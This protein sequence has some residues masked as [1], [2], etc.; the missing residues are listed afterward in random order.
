MRL[1]VLFGVARAHFCSQPCVQYAAV[2]TIMVSQSVVGKSVNYNCVRTYVC[3]YLCAGHHWAIEPW[4]PICTSIGGP[5][6]VCT[7]CV[8]VIANIAHLIRMHVW[9][10]ALLIVLSFVWNCLYVAWDFVW[11]CVC[12]APETWNTFE[13]LSIYSRFQLACF[14]AEKRKCEPTNQMQATYTDTSRVLQIWLVSFFVC[15]CDGTSNLKLTVCV[16]K[17]HTKEAE[18]ASFI[19]R[20]QQKMAYPLHIVRWSGGSTSGPRKWSTRPWHLLHSCAS[21]ISSRG[22]ALGPPPLP[23]Q[24][25]LHGSASISRVCI[26]QCLQYYQ[27]LLP[28]MGILIERLFRPG[29]MTGPGGFWEVTGHRIDKIQDD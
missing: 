24:P 8:L 28:P 9:K 3:M 15:F 20:I 22:E 10:H 27:V 7:V 2:L 12:C 21:L 25:H 29:S 6:C 13:C 5:T 1:K 23:R 19:M 11:F 18:H 17:S 4:C 14:I 26:I 16:W